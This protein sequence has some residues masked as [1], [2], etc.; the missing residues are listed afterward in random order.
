MGQEL[1]TEAACRGIPGSGDEVVAEEGAAKT[2]EREARKQNMTSCS[3]LRHQS[4]DQLLHRW[5]PSF[6]AT[7]SMLLVE[8]HWESAFIT[9][10]LIASMASTHSAASAFHQAGPW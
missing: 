3:Q 4:A 2:S 5:P 1:G 8:A 10:C 6:S 7:L 9:I